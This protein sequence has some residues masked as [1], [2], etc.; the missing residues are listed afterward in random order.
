MPM[1]YYKSGSSWVNALSLFYPVGAYY[2]S[3]SSTNPGSLFGGQWSNVTGRFLYCNNGTGPGGANS[4]SHSHTVNSH[5]HKYEHYH[6]TYPKNL[7]SDLKI[8]TTLDETNDTA[9]K[10]GLVNKYSNAQG[11]QDRVLVHSTTTVKNV[12]I[13]IGSTA[14]AAYGDYTD[15][16]SPGTSSTSISTMPQYRTVYAWYRTT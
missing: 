9:A 11:F 13:D 10:W 1:I 6:S 4:V 7:Y 5:T 3:N 2:I 15:A 16:S 14:K 8:R 12:Y